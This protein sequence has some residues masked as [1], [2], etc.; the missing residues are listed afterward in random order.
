M[1]TQEWSAPFGCGGGSA[2]L[3]APFMTWESDG[4]SAAAKAGLN[5]KAA[6]KFTSCL[7]Q[8]GFVNVQET[9]TKWPL[10]PSPKGKRE[11]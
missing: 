1:E 11:K 5:V 7:E 6:K 8:G 3:D 9:K 4:K 2:P 10:G